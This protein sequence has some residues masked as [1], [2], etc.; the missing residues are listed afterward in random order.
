MRRPWLEPTPL[1]RAHSNAEQQSG[2]VARLAE[3][4]RLRVISAGPANLV[5]PAVA[6]E[7]IVVRLRQRSLRWAGCD[8]PRVINGERLKPQLLRVGSRLQPRLAL[9]CMQYNRI[10]GRE[11]LTSFL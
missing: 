8:V 7:R 9:A 4:R 5:E 1:S 10:G 6:H 11:T 3:A 2:I